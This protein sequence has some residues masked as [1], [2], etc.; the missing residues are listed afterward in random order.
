MRKKFTIIVFIIFISSSCANPLFFYPDKKIYNRFNLK[1]KTYEEVF[2]KSTDNKKLHGVFIRPEKKPHG[3]V[4]HFHGN[5][6]NLTAHLGFVEWIPQYNFNLFVFDYRGYGKSEGSPNR[7]GLYEDC[8][9]AVNFII[10]KKI[11]TVKIFLF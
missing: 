8:I 6:Q 2:F 9:S 1:E 10:K 5:A 7:T 3:T 11:K 4:I